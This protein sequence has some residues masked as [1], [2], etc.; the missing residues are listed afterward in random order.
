LLQRLRT[1]ARSGRT[2]DRGPIAELRRHDR[3]HATEYAAT[4]R[5]WLEALGDPAAAGL[6]LGVHENTVRYRLRKMGEV[7]DLP[8]TDA[9][10]RL[11]MMVELAAVDGD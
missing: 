3:A 8:L 1:A 6:R 4:L 10:K 9:R 2:P 5:A 11:A 7:T